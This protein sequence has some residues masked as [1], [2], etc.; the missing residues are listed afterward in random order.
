MARLQVMTEIYRCPETHQ[1]LEELDEA[2]LAELNEA[3]G[4]G[5]LTDDSGEPVEESLAAGLVRED[6]AY[7]YPVRNGFPNLLISDRIPLD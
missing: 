4:N 1:P 5:E 6:G 7:V 2:R 3:I